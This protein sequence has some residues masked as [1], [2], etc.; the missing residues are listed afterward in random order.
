MINPKQRLSVLEEWKSG[1]GDVLL[2]SINTARYGLNL[3]ETQTAIFVEPPTSPAIL[4]QAEDRLHRIGQLK[5]VYSYILLAGYSDD[6]AYDRLRLKAD[7][8]SF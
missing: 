5:P 2:L 4:D 7:A 1:A 6:E 8:L 3:Q